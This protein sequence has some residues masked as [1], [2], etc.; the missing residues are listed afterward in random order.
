ME[1]IIDLS[2]E[3]KNDLWGYYKLPGLENIIPDVEIKSI[4]TVEKDGFFASKI[5]VS[6]IS[7]TYLEAGSHMIKDGKTL[8]Q[9][10]VDDFIKPAKVIKLPEQKKKSLINRELLEEHA[11]EIN[12]G[13][14]LLIDTGWGKMWN[15]P[16]YVLECPNLLK[17]AL[18]LVLEKDISIFGVDIPCIE[19]AWSDGKEGEK[20]S[21]L[22]VLFQKG[23]LLA[24]P[25]VNMDKITKSE[26]KIICLPIS[27]N[28]T[29]GAPA[30]VIFIEES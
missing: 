18:E 19:A 9:Y 30:R 2:G 21:L 24:A 22:E 1:K 20:G 13:D 6:S 10:S 23:A 5:V 4:A 11:P 26:G 29:S 27:V 12:A 14:A 17:D 7:G 3:L 15:K 25:L 28:G 16:G 8:D